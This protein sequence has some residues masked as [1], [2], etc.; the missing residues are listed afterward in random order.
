M[1]GGKYHG[2][3]G[4]RP[5]SAGRGTGVG[6]WRGSYWVSWA[7][8]CGRWAVRGPRRHPGLAVNVADGAAG[9]P[10]DSPVTITANGANLDAVSLERV[11]TAG[12]SPAFEVAPDSARLNGTLAPDAKYRLVARGHWLSSAP[13]APWQEADRTDLN[14]ERMFSTVSSLGWWPRPN[15]SS[16][17]KGRR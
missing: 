11:D 1:K 6:L 13:R 12:P 8:D 4:G 3:R 9:V 7:Q 2:S 16:P 10:L 14:L 17:R 15:R 5:C